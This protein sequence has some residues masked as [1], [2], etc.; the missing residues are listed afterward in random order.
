M[1]LCLDSGN[2]RVKWGIHDGD[3]WLAQG[4]LAHAEVSRLAEIVDA[5]PGIARVMLANVAGAAARQRI[6]VA[7]G[8]FARRVTEA[9]ST[10]WACGVR[11]HYRIPE[12]LGVDRWCAL[13]G[14]HALVPGPQVVVM[15]GTATTID[16]L[17]GTGAFLGG[18]I[19]PGFDLMLRALA[20]ETAALPFA[21]GV[22]DPYPRGTDDAI[23]TGALEALAGA[24]ERAWRRQCDE[25]ATCVLSGGNAERIS[26]RLS[27]PHQVVANLPLEGLRC[28]ALASQHDDHLE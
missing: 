23:V 11:N 15:A 14:A 20:K 22:Y 21:D 26:Q 9:G 17:D 25:N 2:S 10:A 8:A 28:L 4:A 19:L 7:L 18:A 1:I 3:H 24:V 5:W 6:D 27:I 16:T 12:K 13:L